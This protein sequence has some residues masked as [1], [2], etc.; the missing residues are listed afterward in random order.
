[1]TANSSKCI[2]AD[3]LMRLLGNYCRNKDIKTSIRVGI[4]GEFVIFE[5]SN[6]LEVI[7][8]IAFSEKFIKFAV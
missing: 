5:L 2:G 6:I 7:S 8:D 4:I 1:M 3:I